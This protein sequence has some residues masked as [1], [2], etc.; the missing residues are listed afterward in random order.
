MAAN[1]ILAQPDF[2]KQPH[3]IV[4]TAMKLVEKKAA[5]MA[6]NI[7]LAQP[8]FFKLPFEIVSTAMKLV[9]KKAAKMA[10]NI[11]LAQPDFFKQ[12]HQ[13]VGTAMKLVEKEAAKTVANTILAQP[14]FFKL[15]SE[16]VST[17]MKL[18]EKEAAKTA[19]NTILAQPDFFKLPDQIVS[20]AMKLVE[21]EAAKTAANT[22]LAQ[23]DFF[24][25]PHQIVGTA[26]KL[27]EKDEAITAGR[28]IFANR[29]N[30][31]TF[32][33]FSAIKSLLH[34]TEK[35][36]SDLIKTVVD[37]INNELRY[38][39]KAYDKLHFDLLYLPLF[40]I[41]EHQERALQIIQGYKPSSNRNSKYNVY[42]ILNCYTEYPEIKC[43]QQE[44]KML[45]QNILLR[46]IDDIEYQYKDHP[47][48]LM[49]GH[50]TLALQHPE[51]RTLAL[52]KVKDLVNYAKRNSDFKQ[53]SFFERINNF[54]LE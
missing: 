51:L 38:K 1:I 43:F 39:S 25:Q 15:P 17:A 14:D 50:I 32:I 5:K 10:A 34:S 8:D 37:E 54:G 16:I 20:T 53:S 40:N 45:C 29:Q 30:V 23:P 19:A 42:Q 41:R 28:K 46:C 3:Q 24:K 2:F 11:I 4:G 22:I 35:N 26:M 48:E 49:F 36:D 31:N 13:I 18:V 21:K 47:R 44:I 52:E 6:A 12:P 33:V 7:I 9:E 27:V